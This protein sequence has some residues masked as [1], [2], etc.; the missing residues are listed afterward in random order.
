MMAGRDHAG[1]V[2][3][4]SIGNGRRGR[5]RNGDAYLDFLICEEDL[6]DT[7]TVLSC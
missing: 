3:L 5:E 7:S 1:S 2:D 6:P 4:R